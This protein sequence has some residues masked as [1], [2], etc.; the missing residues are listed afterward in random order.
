MRLLNVDTFELEDFF[1]G[2]VPPYAVLSHTWGSD[3][4]EVSYRDVLNGR[5]HS[6]ATRPPKV[7]GCCVNAK[8][9]GYQYVWIDT[10]CIDKTNSVELQEAINSMF[11]WYRNAAICYA[12]LSDVMFWDSG[13]SSDARSIFSSSRWFKRGWTLQELLAPLNLRFYTV[14]WACMGTKGELCDLVETVTGIPTSFLLGIT[15]LHHAS[16]AQRMSWAANRVTKRQEDLAYCLLGI[17]GVSMPM[18]YGEG[19]KAFRRLQEQI[20]KDVA[21]DSILA[22]GLDLNWGYSENVPG[23]AALGAA[24][25]PTPSHFANSGKVVAMDHSGQDSFEVHGGSLRLPLTLSTTAAGQ[26]LGYLR[27]VYEHGNLTVGIPLVAAPGGQP[28]KYFRVEGRRAIL[29]RDAVYEASAPL[30]HIQL[31][32]ARKSPSQ[33]AG[34]CWFHIPKSIPDLELIGVHPEACWHKERALI[35]AAVEPTADGV[36][37]MLARFRRN[38]SPATEADFVAVLELDPLL[39]PR[40]NLMVASRE[41][42]LGEMACHSDAWAD[43]VARTRSASNSNIRL[44]IALETLKASSSQRRFILKFVL[45]PESPLTTINATTELRAA[46]ATAVLRHL[47][48]IDKEEKTKAEA[49]LCRR[50][51]GKQRLALQE[52]ELERVRAQ[53]ETLRVEER[54][55]AEEVDRERKLESEYLD[56]CGRAKRGE[57]SLKDRISSMTR[58]LE[59]YSEDPEG[60]IRGLGSDGGEACLKVAEQMLPLAV[61]LGYISL[62]DAFINQGVNV[63]A[64]DHRGMT[65]LNHAICRGHEE[66]VRLLIEK[67]ADVTSASKSGATPLHK[68]VDHGSE[69][70]VRLLLSHGA[71]AAATDKHGQTPLDLALRGKRDEIARLLKRH[72]TEVRERHEQLERRWSQEANCE[73]IMPY[74]VYTAQVMPQYVQTPTK[75]LPSN[76][77]LSRTRRVLR[78]IAGGNTPAAQDIDD[79]LPREAIPL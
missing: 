35:E 16:V 78:G 32:G 23:A 44:D 5:L 29:V 77:F 46:G 74:T 11:Q 28:H 45:L 73:G 6:S 1:Y 66:L 27:C 39:R 76:S 13:A 52:A 72:E 2:D 21:D 49:L 8:K 7:N 70:M 17:F 3:S 19:N 63:D 62:A 51:D 15:E 67:G 18:I 12:Y 10:C 56:A 38:T 34:A 58:F 55:L 79:P 20:M 48:R 68:A 60:N 57:L 64:R 54:R 50:R 31:D 25:A 75:P 9:D 24:L 53:I 42:L 65:A 36:R 47:R 59:T 40:C 4:E 69:D 37:R 41:T 26:T 14:G 43:R 22:W 33:A 30:V 61:G 71:D